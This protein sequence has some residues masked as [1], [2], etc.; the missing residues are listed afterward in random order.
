VASKSAI[1]FYSITNFALIIIA[2]N[3]PDRPW[4]WR[5]RRQ[6]EQSTAL[7]DDRTQCTVVA[8]AGR[9]R[10]SPVLLAA[11]R[12]RLLPPYFLRQRSTTRANTA[13]PAF[14]DRSSPRC[15]G[16]DVTFSDALLRGRWTNSAGPRTSFHRGIE[17]HSCRFDNPY[18]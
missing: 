7:S 12:T 1:D 14:I 6:R 17:V 13:L 9:S 2:V 10:R 15:H 4:F 16:D 8:A 5:C 3:L 18:K 11:P